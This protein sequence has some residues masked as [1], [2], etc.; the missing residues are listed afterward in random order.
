MTRKQPLYQD[1]NKKFEIVITPIS[2]E[3]SNQIQTENSDT[4]VETDSEKDCDQ[5]SQTTTSPDK[6]FFIQHGS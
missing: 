5:E 6:I 3:Q 1:Q 4:E 2:D